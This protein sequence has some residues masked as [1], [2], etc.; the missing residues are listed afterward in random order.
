VG[1]VDEWIG[2]LPKALPLVCERQP[3]GSVIIRGRVDTKDKSPS[4][5]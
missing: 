5:S 1:A 2:M 3:D 4:A